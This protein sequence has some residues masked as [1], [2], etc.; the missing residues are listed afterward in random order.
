[1]SFLIRGSEGRRGKHE[2]AEHIF[3]KQKVYR[4]SYPGLWNYTDG[5]V[6]PSDRAP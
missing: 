2:E 1:M 6:C 4:V 5:C 3:E